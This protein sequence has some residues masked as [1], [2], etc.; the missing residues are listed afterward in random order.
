MQGA[1]TN[2]NVSPKVMMRIMGELKELQKTPI[3]GIQIVL[4]EECVTDVQAD[5]V[6]PGMLA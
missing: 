5:I 2:E 6:G 4:N 1:A 3:D